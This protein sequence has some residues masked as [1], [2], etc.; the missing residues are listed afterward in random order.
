MLETITINK[1]DNKFNEVQWG[2][3]LLDSY[4]NTRTNNDY[5]EEAL[6]LDDFWR[7]LDLEE[8][9]I[10]LKQNKF[11][12]FFIRL[13]NEINKEISFKIFVYSRAC[14]MSLRSLTKCATI[15]VLV[16]YFKNN[17]NIEKLEF[18]TWHP[19]LV[20]VVK[21]F[22]NITTHYITSDHIICYISLSDID[23]QA[24]EHLLKEYTKED[25]SNINYDSFKVIY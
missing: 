25:I 13:F 18:T 8:I 2:S 23:K 17:T 1:Y 22:I 19:S 9:H 15:S 3:L 4:N 16:Y 14:P 24:L 20:N 5:T 6:N 21:N 10:V 11:I 7:I 12:G